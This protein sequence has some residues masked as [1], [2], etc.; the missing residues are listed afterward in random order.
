MGGFTPSGTLGTALWSSSVGQLLSSPHF[1]DD[2]LFAELA[3]G[4]IG[5]STLPSLQPDLV[6]EAFVLARL[7]GTAGMQR[8]TRELIAAG[9]VHDH[10]AV[11]QFVRRAVADFYRIPPHRSCKN[12]FLVLKSNESRGPG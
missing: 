10:E 6:G 12:Q 2:R 8:S 5:E 4:S 3:G 7:E 1:F 11:S 9:W